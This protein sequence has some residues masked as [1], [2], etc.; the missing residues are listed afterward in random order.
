M[1]LGDQ[2]II[3]ITLKLLT[4]LK[5]GLL[6]IGVYLYILTS[7][8]QASDESATQDFLTTFKID[9]LKLELYSQQGQCAI[10]LNK[11]TSSET[12]NSVLAIPHPCGFVRRNKHAAVQT[13]Y[14]KGVGHVF[15]VAGPS[16]DKSAYT[17]DAGVKPEHL[18]SNQGQAL[19]LQGD[20]L[21]LR[22]GQY[23]PLG[24]CH[25]LGFD[26]KDFSGYAHPVE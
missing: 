8:C 16:A 12:I 13:Y 5:I 20:V 7:T 18:C 17:K 14:Y 21:K 19:I 11:A 22:R 6:L 3:S 26:E 4:H 24:F 9:D 25:H 2:V 15:V 23:V 10:R 1:V